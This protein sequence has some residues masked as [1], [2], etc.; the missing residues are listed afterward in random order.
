MANCPSI[1]AAAHRRHTTTTTYTNHVFSNSFFSRNLHPRLPVAVSASA[2]STSTQAVAE[3]GDYVEVHYSGTLDDGKEFDSSRHSGREHLSFIIG[4]GRVVPG[5]ETIATGMK[6]GDRTSQRIDSDLA[7]GEWSENLT[8]RVPLSNAPP[9]L[10][11]GTMVQLQN[12]MQAS[13]VEVDDEF[14][15][16]DANH[17]LAGKAL[18]FD[19]ELLKLVKAKDMELATFG[20][21]CFWSVELAFQRVPGVLD[22]A[23]GYCQGAVENVSYEE[24]CRGNTGHNEVVQVMFDKNEVSYEGLLDVFYNKHD[25]TMLNRQGNDVGEQYRSGIYY[26]SEEQKNLAE[27]V[28]AKW[29]EKLS[30]QVVTEVEPLRNFNRAEEYHQQYLAKGGRFGRPQSPNKGCDDPIRCYG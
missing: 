30:G 3:D 10:T 11:Q 23:A 6:V 29:N 25:P 27:E 7:Y 26:H 14:V 20:A 9:G 2:P 12:G 24:V 19:V 13:V 18:T 4:A 17:P 8:A 16:I 1:A 21:G 5:F 28:T 22:T 15:T